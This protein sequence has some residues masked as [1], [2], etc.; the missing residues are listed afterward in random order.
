M[1]ITIHGRRFSVTET[2]KAFWESVEVGKWEPYTFDILD[3][4]VPLH[5][6]YLDIGAWIGPTAMYAHALC[7][8]SFALEPDPVAYSYLRR[9]A[10]GTLINLAISDYD[11][12][13][14]LGSEELGNSMTRLAA[15]HPGKQVFEVKCRTL[16][17]LVDME[18]ISGSIFI[19]MDVEGAEELI[20]RDIE[21][22]KKHKPTLYLSLHPMWFRN[23]ASAEETISK[24]GALYKH[25]IA[26]ENHQLLF[27]D[28]D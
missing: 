21:F 15:V 16:D 10:S 2:H 27:T 28:L 18:A 9:N 17:W 25:R 23:P 4:Y 20:L 26:V 22:F 19:K 7:E 13:M 1:E 11:G 3:K 14:V 8:R 5:D 12:L 24:V 6:N